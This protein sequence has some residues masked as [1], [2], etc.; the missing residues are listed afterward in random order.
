MDAILPAAGLATRM[1]GLPKFLLP[2]SLDYV[3]L[4]ETHIISLLEVCERVWIAVRPETAPLVDI[5][6]IAQDRVIMVNLRTETMSETV[7]KVV[8]LSMAESFMVI[9]PDTH[10]WGEQPHDYLS[11]LDHGMRVAAWNIREDQLGKLG[12]IEIDI[13]S[14][15]V[16]SSKDK[17]P[18]CDYPFAWGAVAFDRSVTEHI[19]PASPHIGFMI[20]EVIR[21]GKK[22]RAKVMA[23][24]YFDCGTPVEY[25]ALLEKVRMGE[26]FAD[27]SAM[28]PSSASTEGTAVG[29]R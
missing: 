28:L 20:P 3:T 16:I 23:G 15:T 18:T 27:G 24:S 22:I 25:F 19:D 13:N 17:D 1:R 8:N 26:G 9:V 12:Q 10:F 5:L 14:S 4:L 21:S 6:Q 2:C 11:K 7:L 29:H